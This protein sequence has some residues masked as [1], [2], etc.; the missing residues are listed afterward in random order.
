VNFGLENSDGGL[1]N[2]QIGKL[3]VQTME[4]DTL[5]ALS[6]YVGELGLANS[7]ETILIWDCTRLMEVSKQVVKVNNSSRV[8]HEFVPKS[9]SRHWSVAAFVLANHLLEVPGERQHIRVLVLVE[10]KVGTH[11]VLVLS[12]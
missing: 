10:Q 3:D 4:M 6:S 8:D 11:D 12:D 1:F 9:R 2:C 7:V 5:N